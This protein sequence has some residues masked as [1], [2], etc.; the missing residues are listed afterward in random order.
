MSKLKIIGLSILLLSLIVPAIAFS[1]YEDETVPI[2]VEPP[3]ELTL[4]PIE[5]ADK[6]SLEYAI[7]ANLFK[8]VMYC[9]S[10][11]RP[12]P[13]GHNDGGNAFGIMQFHKTTFLGYEKQIGLDL[14][15]YSYHDQIRLAAYMFSV[16]Q[17][18][19]W[20]CTKIVKGA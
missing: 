19:Q 9:E 14:D 6:Y 15:Y 5:Y 8:K 16:G 4:T 13:P 12:N 17:A 3:K 18:N 2:V 10:K 20:T 1:D 7:D 11:N